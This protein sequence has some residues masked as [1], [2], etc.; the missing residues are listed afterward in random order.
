VGRVVLVVLRY[1]IATAQQESSW[2]VVTEHILIAI[3]VI[4]LTHYVVD[5]I[6]ATFTSKRAVRTRLNDCAKS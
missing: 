4:T 1:T 3:V 5:W 6:N 2:R